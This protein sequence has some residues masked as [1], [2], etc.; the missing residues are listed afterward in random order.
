M[1]KCPKKEAACAKILRIK[2]GRQIEVTEANSLPRRRAG[3]K[4]KK[5]I[6]SDIFWSAESW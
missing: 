3:R 2:V 4:A 1:R 6:L 5:S